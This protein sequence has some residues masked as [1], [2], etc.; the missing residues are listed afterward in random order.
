MDKFKNLPLEQGKARTKIFKKEVNHIDFVRTWVLAVEKA[1][2]IHWIA[3]E[4]GVSD[5]FIRNMAG[6]L[7][8]HGVS[9][10]PLAMHPRTTRFGKVKT[11][12]L[13]KIIKNGS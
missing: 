10:P 3:Q 7:R 9:L 6:R 8:K 12:E 5:N 11:D 2:G 4:L 1:E 13:N